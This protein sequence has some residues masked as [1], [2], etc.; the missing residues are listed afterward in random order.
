MS[1]AENQP[2]SEILR[3][4]IFNLNRTCP[5]HQLLNMILTELSPGKTV[6]KMCI[7]KEH[8]NLQEIAHGGVTFSLADTAMGLGVRA[9]NL[10]AATIEMNINYLLPVQLG[11]VLTAYGKV[12]NAGKKIIIA[13]AEI[14]NQVDQLIATSRGTYYSK[15]IYLKNI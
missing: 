14:Y 7:T 11:D 3:N 6:I 8:M 4:D 12:I 13:E 9:L 10:V 15:G 2:M 5:Y 1:I